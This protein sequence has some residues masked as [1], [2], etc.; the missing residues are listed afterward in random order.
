[1]IHENS[2]LKKFSTC[3]ITALTTIALLFVRGN[4]GTLRWFSPPVVF[5]LA[6]LMLLFGLVYPFIW[7]RREVVEKTDSAKLYGFFLCYNPVHNCI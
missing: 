5:S 1:V 3:L 4:S 2:F 7:Q 6:G